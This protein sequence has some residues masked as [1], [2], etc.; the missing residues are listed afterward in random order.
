MTNPHT[1]CTQVDHFKDHLIEQILALAMLEDLGPG[2]LD[3]TSA[4]TIPA[5]EICRAKLVLKESSVVCG[6]NIFETVVKCLSPQSKIDIVEL[7][8]EGTFVE[9][10]DRP[11]PVAEISAD[12]RTL[13]AAERLSLNLIQRMCGVATITSTYTKIAKPAKIQIFLAGAGD[14]VASTSQ[15]EIMRGRLCR[16]RTPPPVSV[17]T[18][19]VSMH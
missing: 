11:V 3:V 18:N 6:I 16:P 9:V 15:K 19:V 7:V 5:S 14:Y 4:A 8:E 1:S 12:S 2:P 17:Q 13:L 10:K